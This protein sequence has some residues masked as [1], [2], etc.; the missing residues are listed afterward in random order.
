MKDT[1]L[2]LGVL[3]IFSVYSFKGNNNDKEQP[4]R[5][6]MSVVMEPKDSALTDAVLNLIEKEIPVQLGS[7]PIHEVDSVHEVM[8]P[9]KVAVVRKLGPDYDTWHPSQLNR[10]RVEDI[11]SEWN[12]LRVLTWRLSDSLVQEYRLPIKQEELYDHMMKIYY[13]E[14]K[15]DPK[16]R[17]RKS[18]AT[19][20]IQ[21]MGDKYGRYGYSRKEFANLGVEGQMKYVGL[22]FRKM[23][24]RHKDNLDQLDTW[25]DYYCLVFYP[26]AAD[27]PDNYR[28]A[29]SCTGKPGNCYLK[30]KKGHYCTYHANSGYDFNKDGEIRKVEIEQRIDYKINLKYRSG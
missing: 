18:S 29:K 13:V 16:A 12:K 5:V 28:I 4:K 8:K 1:Y 20:L 25:T 10:Y 7:F 2:L 26:R 22:Y 19:G 24:D 23:L 15:F 3:F 14:S 21:W 11:V 17:N 6:N 30:K 27:K 9:I